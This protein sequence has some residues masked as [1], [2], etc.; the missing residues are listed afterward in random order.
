MALLNLLEA[1][2][3]PLLTDFPDDEPESSG[4]STVLACPVFFPQETVETAETDR[5]KAAFHREIAAMRPWYDM[6]VT[7]RQRTTVGISGIPLEDLE[8][9][10]YTFVKDK[11]PENPRKDLSLA[12]ALK[13]AVEDL[14]S[15]YIE[16]ITSQP[17]QEGASSRTLDEWFWGETKAGEVLLQVKRV[18]ETSEERTMKM[19]GGHFLVPGKFARHK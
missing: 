2:G 12:F 4:E 18:C 5:L 19:V 3:G 1:P 6:A 15:Y 11:E 14:K 8:D 10:I 9:F 13:F 7:R 17:G 16:A